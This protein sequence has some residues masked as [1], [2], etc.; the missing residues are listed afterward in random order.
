[1]ADGAIFSINISRDGVPKRPT[2]SAWIGVDGVEGDRQRD[3]RY[4]GGADRA[5]SLYSFELIQALQAEGHSVAPGSLG[6]NLTLTGID[7]SLMIPGAQLEAGPVLLELTSYVAPCR[8]VARSFIN[9]EFVR[10]SQKVNPGWSRLYA[11]VLA[12]G[13]VTPGLSAFVIRD[14]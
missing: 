8:N 14:S 13:I 9:L 2:S 11:R 7:W 5:V 1:M 3:R 10:V 4:H 12:E 6:E